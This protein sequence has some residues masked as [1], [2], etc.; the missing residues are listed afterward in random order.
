MKRIVAGKTYNT[1]T[2]ARVAK[3]QYK[4]DADRDVEANVY[5]NKGGAFFIVHEWEGDDGAK[6]V[7]FESSTRKNITD[8]MAKEKFIDNFEIVDEKALEPPPE[9][10]TEEEPGATV[11]VRVPISLKQRVDEAAADAKL[12]G[13]SYML[14][15]MEH[16]LKD[17]NDYKPLAHI[18]DIASG[19]RAHADDGQ[20]SRETCI[21]ALSEIADLA[22]ELAGELF[23]DKRVLSD[24]ISSHWIELEDIRKEYHP[25]PE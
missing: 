21:R 13:N 20:W 1:D 14:R 18:W 11:Y 17:L 12:S 2:S 15:C 7:Y 3:Y 6:K 8:L 16:C 25:Y 23:G 10:T 24:W 4:D 9:A 19:F 5:V 22:E